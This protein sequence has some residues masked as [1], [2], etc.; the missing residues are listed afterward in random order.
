MEG[1]H[2]YISRWCSICLEGIGSS[3]KSTIRLPDSRRCYRRFLR[4]PLL[5]PKTL[6][7]RRRLS[8]PQQV[9]DSGPPARGNNRNCACKLQFS[10]E[11]CTHELLVARCDPNYQ[12]LHVT[13]SI[14]LT[15]LS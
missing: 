15:H 8:Q 2:R 11:I 5:I 14:T 9:V 13:G 6:V 12:M 1:V 10:N 3:S 4:M 7:W